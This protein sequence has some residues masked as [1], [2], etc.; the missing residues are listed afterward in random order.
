MEIKADTELLEALAQYFPD[1]KRNTL[2]KMLTE[3]R[4][5]VDGNVVH[6]AKYIVK[7]NVL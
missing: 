5:L 2:R 4:A 3:G 1:S 7:K 6:K